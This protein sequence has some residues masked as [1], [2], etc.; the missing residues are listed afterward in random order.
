M[1]ITKNAQKEQKYHQ[2]LGNYFTIEV[3]T[4]RKEDVNTKKPPEMIKVWHQMRKARKLHSV[5][6]TQ[7][8]QQQGAGNYN[9]MCT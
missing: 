7:S 2:K 3:H 8:I 4:I 9:K 1:A 6:K 5:V